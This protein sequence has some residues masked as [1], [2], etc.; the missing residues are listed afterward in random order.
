MNGGQEFARGVIVG[1]VDANSEAYVIVDGRGMASVRR[2]EDLEEVC[3][4][5]VRGASQRRVL[6]CMNGGYALMCTGTVIRAWEVEHGGYLYN[7][8][9]R[10][11]GDLVAMVADDRHVAAC[12]GDTTIH[13][14]DFGAQ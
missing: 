12:N 4:F 11:L 1:S 10:M 14:W 9:E 5:I 8:R 7:L 13:L 2:A 3:R 6:G